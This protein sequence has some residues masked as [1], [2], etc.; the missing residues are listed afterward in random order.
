M[1]DNW[2]IDGIRRTYEVEIRSVHHFD[3]LPTFEH[4]EQILV[5]LQQTWI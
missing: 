2:Y 1:T 4:E 5:R 3:K